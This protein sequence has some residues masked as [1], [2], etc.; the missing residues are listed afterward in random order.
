MATVSLELFK[1]H[2][3]ADD[4]TGE[5]G[6]MEHLLETAEE[7]VVNAT[8]RTADELAEMGGGRLPSSLVHAVLMLAGHWYNQR[9]S[10]STVQMHEVPD[11]FQSLVKPFRKLVD[12]AGREDEH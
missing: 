6:Y 3:R 7:A 9:E 11:A 4:F 10:V 12:D 8:Q 5:D 1:Q 2:V